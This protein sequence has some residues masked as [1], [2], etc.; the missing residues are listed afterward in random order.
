MGSVSRSVAGVRLA[1]VSAVVLALAVGGHVLG[2]GR[3]VPS[4]A[5]VLLTGPVLAGSAVLSRR[6]LTLRTLVPFLATAQLLVHATSSWFTPPPGQEVATA[7]PGH[8]GEQAAGAVVAVTTTGVDHLHGGATL[9]MLAAHVLATAVSAVL[10]VGTDRAARAAR[11]WCAT[12]LP[13]LLT[14]PAPV[15]VP[16]RQVATPGHGAPPRARHAVAVHPRR[17]PPA[18]LATG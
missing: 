5:L 10:L 6:R 4:G 16:R 8:H 13:S 18:V 15:V 17:G 1:G 11:H 12:V 7:T 14:G 3:L 9:H 2:G